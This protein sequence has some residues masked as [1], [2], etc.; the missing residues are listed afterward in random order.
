MTTMK[1]LFAATALALVAGPGFSDTIRLGTEG[2]YP[3]YNFINEK[4]EIDGFEKDLGDALCERAKLDCVW[5]KNDWDTI[6]PNLVSGNYDAILAGMNPTDE[7]R[8]SIQFS[9]EY[10]PPTPSAFIALSPDVDLKDGVIAAQ[11]GTIHASWLAEN[12]YTPLEF[13]TGEEGIAAVRNG[14]AEALFLDKDFLEPYVKDSD[15][16]LTFAG[17]DVILAEGISIGL[18]KSDDALRD[19]FNTVITE[20]KQDGSLNEMIHKWFGDDALTF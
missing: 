13:A 7:R 14:E 4:G 5:V 20:M 8:K 1:L 17:E 18:R 9:D 6:I 12:G 3:P 2:G 10:L 15:G 11:T 19:E 16:A